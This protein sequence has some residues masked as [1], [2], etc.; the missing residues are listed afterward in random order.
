MDDT[1]ARR[2]R[3][4]YAATISWVDTQLGRVLDE[5]SA[6]GL[7]NDTI[8]VMHSDHGWS[9]GEQGEWQKFTNFELGARVPLVVRDPLKPAAVS[10]VVVEL[11]DVMPTLMDLAGVPKS[12]LGDEILDGSSLRPFLGGEGRNDVRVALSLYARCPNGNHPSSNPRDWW[13]NSTCLF[14][15]RTLYS[16]VGL[17]LRT[18]RWRYTEWLWWNGARERPHWDREP[19][20]VELYDHLGDRGLDF[21]AFET[22]NLAGNASH[23]EEAQELAALLRKLYSTPQRQEFAWV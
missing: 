1:S 4:Y 22:E 13:K 12:A 2:F 11:V 19:A 21:D 17:S 16:F 7:S 9:L 8:V 23:A 15:D 6:T 18:D 3:L 14:I 5:L 10:D 20:A